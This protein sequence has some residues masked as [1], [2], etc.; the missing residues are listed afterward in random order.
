MKLSEAIAGWPKPLCRVMWWCKLDS[1]RIAV[2][3]LTAAALAAGLFTEEFLLQKDSQ[4]TSKKVEQ[5]RDIMISYW[6]FLLNRHKEIIDKWDTTECT[7]D[8]LISWLQNIGL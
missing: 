6:P 7:R 2:C 5:L 8:E 1:G 3:P 4:S